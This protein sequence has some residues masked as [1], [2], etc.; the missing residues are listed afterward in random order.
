MN[1]PPFELERYFSVH[2]FTAKRLMCVSDCQPL[3]VA[4]LLSLSDG[5]AEAFAALPM[6]YADSRGGPTLRRAICPLY[7]SVTP[8]DLLVHVGAEE[9]IFT[10]FSAIISPGDRVIVQTPCYRSLRDVPAALG[11]C[12]LEWPGHQENG[13]IPDLDFLKTALMEKTRAVVVNFPHNPTGALPDQD[14]FREIVR[15]CDAAGALLFSD[16]VYRFLEYDPADR[17]PAACDLSESAVSLGVMSKSFGLAGLRVGWVASKNAQVLSGMA[18]IKDYTSICGSPA[19]EFLAALALSHREDVLSRTRAITLDN[20]AAARE[21][22]AR[23]EDR[24]V[25]SAPKAGPIAFP[26]LADGGDAAAFAKRLLDATGALLLPGRVYGPYASHFR[27]GFGRAGFIEGLA[28]LDA[29]L[30]DTA[31]PGS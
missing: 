9:A 22:M 4:E 10:F 18:R 27:L 24:F 30:D 14:A 21:F 7:A 16:E 15:L 25:W 29:F 13:W 1:L 8:D 26:R 31:S 19:T 12:V 20:L 2:E 6:G 28:V 3:T 17:L 5:A 11:A 23:R